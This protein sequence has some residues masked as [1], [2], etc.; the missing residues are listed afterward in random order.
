METII[1]LKEVAKIL[2]LLGALGLCV[3]VAVGLVK[4][5]PH[6]RRLTENLATTTQ[7]TAKITGDFA[8]VSADVADDLRKTAA[9]T[10]AGAEHLAT[11]AEAT[12]K[13][14][15]DFADVSAGVADDLRKFTA[16]AA[17]GAE[18][19]ADTAQATAKITGDFADVSA[20]VA[21]DIRQTAASTAETAKNFAELLGVPLQIVKLVNPARLAATIMGE[22]LAAT[23]W[24]N[25]SASRRGLP[26]L[27]WGKLAGYRAR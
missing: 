15:G 1:I 27:S 25:R 9:S 18:H 4:L 8:A 5:F 14:A 16:S 3:I 13:I 21:G 7:S 26:Q 11:T 20:D 19:L 24:R 2:L 17:A 22:A 12:A 10:A 6:L 23:S